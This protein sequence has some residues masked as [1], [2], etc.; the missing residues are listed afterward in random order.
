MSESPFMGRRPIFIGD[1][2]TDEDAFRIVNEMGGYSVKVGPDHS[3]S[4][5]RYRLENVAAVHDWLDPLADRE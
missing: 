2:V 4:A 3:A 1:D 5:A